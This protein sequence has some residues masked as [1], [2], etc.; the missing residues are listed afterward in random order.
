MLA[1]DAHQH[2]WPEEVLRA[3]AGRT[4]APR[5]AW[6]DGT[7]ILELPGE[8]A[9]AVDPADHDP[10]AR[11]AQ[12]RAAGLDQVLLALS[13]P[14]GIEALPA[15]EAEAVLDAWATAA[16]TLPPGLE[17]WAPVALD[18]PAD[19]VAARAGASLDAG[20]VGVVVAA[21][22]LRT[23]ADVERLGPLLSLLEA[24]LSPLFVHPGPAPWT[25]TP[26]P[27]EPWWAPSVGYVA[28]LH[29]AW[30]AVSAW[31]RPAHPRLA[32]LF[33]AC[34]GLA[35]VH[36]E[37]TALRGGPVADEPDPLL[38]YDTSSYGERGLHAM[39]CAVGS[40][41]LVH[42]TD[43]PVVAVPDDEPLGPDVARAARRENAARMLGRLWTPF[44]DAAAI[45]T[46]TTE[47]SA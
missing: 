20:A 13:T 40:A 27:A 21:G 25:P 29:A 2:L 38:F 31:A 24:R 35:P 42:G 11:G 33:A 5:A 36:A 32:V 41:Q 28:D 22:A 12:A 8:P 45:T 39:C 16:R 15:A 1:V 44:G 3:L 43:A 46:T 37:R 34:A 4:S 9:F 10:V 47:A 30:H 14:V 23:P 17:T 6:A 19:H 18:A 26:P 7:W